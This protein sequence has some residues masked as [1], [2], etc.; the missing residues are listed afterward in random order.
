MSTGGSRAGGAKT[1]GRK[2]GS[3]NKAT[4]EIKE[5]AQ[6]FGP[7][8]IERLA[9]LSGLTDKPAAESEQTQL[10]A[11]RELLDRGYGKAPQAITGADGGAVQMNLVRRVIVDPKHETDE[12]SSND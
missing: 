4:A 12:R 5:L 11:M 3:L 2:P 9:E 1:G 8:T 6:K 7:A 10:G